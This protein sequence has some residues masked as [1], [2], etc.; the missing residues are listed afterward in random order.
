LNRFALQKPDI[1]RK[2][3]A[4]FQ[5]ADRCKLRII[6]PAIV[7]GVEPEHSQVRSQSPEMTV[8]HK[9]WTLAKND[10]YL[11]RIDLNIV[12]LHH[13]RRKTRRPAIHGNA[14]NFGMR[15]AQRLDHM[16]ER[17]RCSCRMLKYYM[18]LIAW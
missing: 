18:P 16:L 11:V 8:N 14:A 9:C 17:V 5:I 13:C 1:A 3:N 15:D 4:I 7:P 12:L 2:Q 6:G 10:R